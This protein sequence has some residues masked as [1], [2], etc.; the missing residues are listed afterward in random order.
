M[1]VSSK[2]FYVVSISLFYYSC[3]SGKKST[4]NKTYFKTAA[5]YNHYIDYRFNEVNRL[6]NVTLTYMDDS[7]LV[8]KQLDSLKY[9]TQIAIYDMNKLS[10]F[11][12]DTTYK[13]RAAQYFKYILM[14]TQ[15]DLVEA[16]EIGLMENI[17]DSLYFR[18]MEIG[19]QIG[20]NKQTYI[21]QLRAAQRNFTAIAQ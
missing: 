8:Y 21:N 11:K 1:S 18:Y 15:N 13:Y 17:S 9:A 4:S 5:E 2:I 7:L 3:G 10:D 19:N 16:I 12:G 6:W 14:T 20:A